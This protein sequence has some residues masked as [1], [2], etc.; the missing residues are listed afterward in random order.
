MPLLLRAPRTMAWK[1]NSE[2]G[3][4]VAGLGGFLWL[5]FRVL[6]GSVIADTVGK[7]SVLQADVQSLKESIAEKDHKLDMVL[8]ELI[9]TRG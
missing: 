4:E 6:V 2:I 5:I 3:A 9:R 8:S 7:I 1:D